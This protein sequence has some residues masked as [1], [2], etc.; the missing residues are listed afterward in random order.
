[1]KK[2][3]E[4]D[5]ISI[6]HRILQLKN[7]SDI[8]QLYLETQKLYE[9]L[10]V[11][12]F[13]DEHFSEAKPTIGAAEIEQKIESIFDKTESVQPEAKAVIEE[14]VVEEIAETPLEQAT[15]TADESESE[16]NIVEEE[17]VEVPLEETISNEEVT[18]EE[19][20]EEAIIEEEIVVEEKETSAPETTA[21]TPAFELS[22]EEE[23]ETEVEAPKKMEPVQISFEDLLGGNYHDTQ[24]VKVQQIENIPTAVVIETPKEI[25]A[26]EEKVLPVKEEAVEPK[27][28]SLNEKLA[29]GIN[30]DLNDRIAFIK[31]LFGNS[32]EDYNRVLNQLI[33]FD[34]FYET[35]D[36]I[37][38]MVKPD[39]NNWEGKQEYE[40][41]FMDIIEKKFL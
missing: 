10:S 37:Q 41:R 8:N 35:R 30:I 28:V 7:K 2:K 21:F 34:T 38:E 5:L 6:A 3:L 39:Y 1:M 13:V 31:H 17:T 11:L 24:F 14:T 33:T 32:S 26:E 20:K 9:K 23:V 29:K 16:T 18:P 22:Q 12:R 40:E 19:E 15:T 27:T 4:A 25:V 36:F